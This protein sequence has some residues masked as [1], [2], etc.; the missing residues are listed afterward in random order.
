M[1]IS[2]TPTPQGGQDKYSHVSLLLAFST[3]KVASKHEPLLSRYFPRICVAK[4]IFYVKKGL[5]LG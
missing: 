3:T 4:N 5:T 1:I 2:V